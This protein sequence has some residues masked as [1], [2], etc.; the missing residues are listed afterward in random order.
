MTKNERYLRRLA[1][2]HGL[3]LVRGRSHWQFRDGNW[4]VA[5][6]AVSPSDRRGMKNLERDLE[7][8]MKGQS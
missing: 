5:V 3:E 8:R 1:A 6:T 7:R 2:K 4:L